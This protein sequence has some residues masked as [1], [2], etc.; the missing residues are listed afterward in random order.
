MLS[1]ETI[2]QE[3]HWLNYEYEEAQVKVDLSDMILEQLVDEIVSF[4]NEQG[5][6]LSGVND[7]PKEESKV[8]IVELYDEPEFARTNELAAAEAA[9]VNAYLTGPM[10]V[11]GDDSTSSLQRLEKSQ[12]VEA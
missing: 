2:E 12:R 11:R 1:A 9:E 5:G 7:T 10:D 4:L 3:H 6:A 8:E